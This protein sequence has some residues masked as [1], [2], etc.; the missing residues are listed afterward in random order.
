MNV[1]GL[2]AGIGG[3]ELGLERA[4]ARI[5]LLCEIDDCARAV[6]RER[7]PSARLVRDVR[8]VEMLP[9]NIDLVT[10]GF[11]CQDLSQVGSTAG[12]H[13]EQSGLVREV[14]RL[15]ERTRPPWVLIENVPFMLRL[16]GGRGI[17]Y[18]VRKLES[19]GYTWA[20][21][22]IDSR[23]F[24]LPQ[25]RE[26]VFLL[27]SCVEDPA[28]VLFSGDFEWQDPDFAH[29]MAHGFYWTEGNRGL[30]WA[31]SA[32]PAIKGGSGWGIPSPPA[33]WFPDGR[34]GT[35]HIKDAERLQGF[36]AD[37]TKP[38]ERVARLSA[39]WAL[40]GNAVPVPIARWLGRRLIA[41]DSKVPTPTM[42]ALKSGDRWPR[43]AYGSA[44]GRFSVDVG[45][46]PTR[47]K[48][49]HLHEF[50]RF[51]ARPLS[52]RAVSG[53]YRR[54]QGSCLRRPPAFDEALAAY[55]GKG[56]R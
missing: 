16:Q 55:L 38:S 7:F 21:R 49:P 6:L 42:Q 24:G 34:F 28:G 8:A 2:F 17:A 36:P 53:F 32:V 52:S 3:F 5:A 11:P 4:G 22:T 54:L 35:P 45:H 41:D 46:Y 13:G 18:V 39:R 51:E 15:L 30:G 27:A 26:R 43:A 37:W 20:Y 19:L 50:L 23:S 31:R 56:R 33:I 29:P 40:V 47:R 12:I 25:R 48:V 14:F 44:G 9:R 1:A 10:A